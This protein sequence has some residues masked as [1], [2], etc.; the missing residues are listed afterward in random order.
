MS[1]LPDGLSDS[2]RNCRCGTGHAHVWGASINTNATNHTGKARWQHTRNGRD[3][4]QPQEK[5]VAWL[6]TAVDQGA[7]CACG[8]WR[9]ELGTEPTPDL[10]VQHIVEVFRAVRRVLRDDGVL[11]LNVG[12]SYAGGRGGRDWDPNWGSGW[13]GTHGEQGRMPS[14]ELAGLKPKDLVGIPWRLAFAL[15]ADGWW[16][17]SEVIWHKPNP[18]PESVTDR[19]TKAHEQVFLLAKSGDVQFWMHP[20]GQ[21]ARSK[22][23]P[24][25]RWKNRQTGETAAIEPPGWRE[26]TYAKDGQQHRLW[27]RRDLWEAHDY[28]YDAEAIKESVTGNAHA[29]GNGVHPK[30]AQPGSGIKA[31]ES[32]SAAVRGLVTT[33]NARSVWTIATQP[34]PVAHFATFPQELPERCILAGTSERGA[35]AECGAPRVRVVERVST[36]KSM[37]VGKSSAKRSVGLATAFSGYDDGSKAPCFKTTGWAPTCSHAAPVVPCVVLDPFSGTGTTGKAAAKLGRD[38]I[39]IDLHP[40]HTRTA[41]RRL[42]HAVEGPLFPEP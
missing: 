33:R 2:L 21:G 7:L 31:N 38:Y 11:W 30:S 5:R 26:L 13:K 35:C 24:D 28:F 14:R 36:G 40:A 41:E 12:D 27:S 3:E 4:E 37:A 23:A 18:M 15:Q 42:T 16:L 32:F 22:P 1:A 17:R 10:Y 19:P 39:G 34:S 20:A 8:A 29:R 6:R 9:G 25:W